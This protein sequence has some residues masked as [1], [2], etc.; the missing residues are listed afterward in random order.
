MR[1]A[2][3][4]PHAVQCAGARPTLCRI[5][6]QELIIV[7]LDVGPH[8]HCHLEL[9]S[10]AVFNMV[11]SK[12]RRAGVRGGARGTA[13]QCACPDAPPPPPCLQL[14]WKPAHEVAVIYFGTTG[15]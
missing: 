10:Q 1:C 6:L 4:R 8:M 9:T 5:P 13:R 14:L 11:L 12:V 15:A 7:L 3:A 2:T